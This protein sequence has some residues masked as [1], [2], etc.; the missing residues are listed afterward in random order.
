MR[1]QESKL[2]ERRSRIQMETM[3][4]K[5]RKAK[6]AKRRNEIQYESRITMKRYSLI[7]E[8]LS[9]LFKKLQK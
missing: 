7:S 1:C 8:N 3:I 4:K 2:G 9:V 5:E 6:R